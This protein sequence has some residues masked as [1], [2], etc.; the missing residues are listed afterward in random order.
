MP[1]SDRL[2]G[3][4]HAELTTDDAGRFEVRH[5]GP[6]TYR[7]S[8]GGAAFTGVALAATAS[9]ARYARVSRQVELAAGEDRGELLVH[10]PAP[11]SVRVVVRR[12]DGSPA[13]GATVFARGEDGAPVDG[14][15]TVRTDAEGVALY[16]GLPPGQVTLRARTGQWASLESGSVAVEPGG[17]AEAE[18]VLVA[19]TELRVRLR[20]PD[21]PV[22]G[23]LSVFD[24]AGR[25]VGALFGLEDLERLFSEDDHDPSQFVVGPLPPGRYRLVAEGDGHSSGEK[26]VTLDGAPRHRTTLRLE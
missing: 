2:W 3:G 5:L 20:G 4:Q 24:D 7:L 21:G 10:L 12:P 26:N 1:R 15:S 8:V 22:P 9:P 16:S 23:A 25:E 18:L 6:G 17:T 13:V 14:S 11:G 19:G